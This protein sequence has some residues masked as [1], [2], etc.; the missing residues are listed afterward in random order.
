MLDVPQT[1]RSTV[2]APSDVPSHPLFP[3]FKDTGGAHSRDFSS[4]ECVALFHSLSL[5]VHI[6]ARKVEAF[7]KYFVLKWRPV[8]SPLF[9][10]N[11]EVSD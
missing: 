2:C 9:K 6:S 3:H 1:Q 10:K 4:S 5:V 7:I 11:K 8:Y